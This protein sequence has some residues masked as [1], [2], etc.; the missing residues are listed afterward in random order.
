MTT[1]N[2][3]D[4][5]GQDCQPFNPNGAY[6]CYAYCPLCAFNGTDVFSY[7]SVNGT[8]PQYF[9]YYRQSP[10]SDDT[11][12]WIVV[13]P[14]VILGGSLDA[15]TAGNPGLGFNNAGNTTQ[16]SYGVGFFPDPVP[17][18]YPTYLTYN[19]GF[20]FDGPLEG[21][22]GVWGQMSSPRVARN[23]YGYLDP[24]PNSSPR[25]WQTYL[26]YYD[27]GIRGGFAVSQLT[28]TQQ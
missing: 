27:Q 4:Y 6:G 2:D 1:F 13:W 15:G 12:N 20:Y 10:A 14:D 7:A 25:T 3:W 9:W 28:I 19:G 5:H 17:L 18:V 22:N 11:G 8:S 21:T 24:V 23:I 26:Y 16:Y